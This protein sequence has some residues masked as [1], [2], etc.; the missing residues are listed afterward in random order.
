MTGFSGRCIRFSNIEWVMSK[1]E[2][3]GSGAASTSWSKVF[4][5]QPTKPSGAFLRLEDSDWLMR[6]VSSPNF[7]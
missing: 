3:S 1:E 2:V 6:L 4:S 7:A 5:D